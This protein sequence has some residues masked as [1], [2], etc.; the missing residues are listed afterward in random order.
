VPDLEPSDVVND[1]DHHRLVMA[2]DG[3]EAELMYERVG[4]QLLLIHTEVPEEIA[5]QGIAAS[6]VEAAVRWAERD[7]LVIVPWCPYVRKR[8][9]EHPDVAAA[10]QIDWDT[11]PRR[12]PG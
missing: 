6:L 8:L 5:G 2:R 4:N 9:Q 10:V 11:L 7:T 12:R 3:Q 1:E